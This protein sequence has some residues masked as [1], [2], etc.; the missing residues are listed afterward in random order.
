VGRIKN[1][2]TA[3]D[4]KKSRFKD[5]Y[6]FE[7]WVID[8]LRT[9]GWLVTSMKDSRKQHWNAHKGIEDIHAARY[10]KLLY[11]ELKMPSNKPTENQAQW[12]AA[13]SVF[14]DKYNTAAG[15]ELIIVRLW[16]PEHEDEIIQVAGGKYPI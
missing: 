16:Y 5:E 8:V 9:N 6:Q 3:A 15:R 10:N 11:A 2:G 13:H 1:R 7:A 4:Y 12:L 14:A